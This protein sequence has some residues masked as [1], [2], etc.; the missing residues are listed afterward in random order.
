MFTA[1]R[2]ITVAAVMGLGSL[3]I[4]LTT[5]YKKPTVRIK[6][7][8]QKNEVDVVRI[9]KEVEDSFMM[10]KMLVLLDINILVSAGLY[11]SLKLSATAIEISERLIFSIK[12]TIY[13][14]F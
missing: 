9:V 1:F 8:L 2:L 12:P 4:F 11:P 14:I 10:K 13:K 6:Y 7:N 5:L 3:F